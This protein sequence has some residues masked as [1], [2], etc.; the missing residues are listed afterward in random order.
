MFL[1]NTAIRKPVTTVMVMAAILVFGFIGFTRLGVDQFPK[2]EY[3]VVTVMTLLEGASPEV[4]EENITD[5]IEE[6][7]STV[8]GV[9]KLT[10]TSSHG[11]SIV[12]IEFEMEYDIDIAT[13]DIRDRVSGVERK[14][15]DEAERPSVSKMDMSARPIMWVA[16]SGDRPIQEITH[17]AEEVLKLEDKTITVKR[18]IDGGSETLEGRIPML[19]TVVKGATQ[20]RPF[21]AKR[22]MVYKNAKT[23]L[24]VEKMTNDNSLLSLDDLLLEYKNKNLYIETITTEDLSDIDLTRLGLHG[25]PTKV[26][27]VE[28]VVLSGGDAHKVEPTKE[29]IGDLIDELLNDHI[30]G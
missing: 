15:P 25:S 7:L 12:V 5:I 27:K 21:S 9:K 1:P 18:K 23:L 14:L 2:V 8:E 28:S 10:S 13:Q 19:I 6:E 17:Y 29:G 22:V 26:H 30:L 24:D 20:P 11:A 4:V 16:V 3:P